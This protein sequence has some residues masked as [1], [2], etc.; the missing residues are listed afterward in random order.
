[1]LALLAVTR[2]NEEDKATCDCGKSD[3]LP[4][5]TESNQGGDTNG[6]EKY[7]QIPKMFMP[8]MYAMPHLPINMMNQGQIPNPFLQP[9][10]GEKGEP[11]AGC[12]ACQDDSE[13]YDVKE[14]DA[15]TPE[16]TLNIAVTTQTRKGDSSGGR[17]G[18]LRGEK[19]DKGD[20]GL[21]GFNGLRGLPGPP[22]QPGPPGP[23]GPPYRGKLINTDTHETVEDKSVYELTIRMST[24]LKF[25]R[26]KK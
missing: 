1:M 15:S 17:Y 26:N 16:R 3:A 10:K 9:I 25:Q 22:G 4:K 20:R 7:T 2:A 13:I 21:T 18:A 8:L 19:G 11:G 6:Y 5:I 12:R 14:G 24:V 23:P